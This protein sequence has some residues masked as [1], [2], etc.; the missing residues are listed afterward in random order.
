MAEKFLIERN[1]Y[2]LKG[3]TAKSASKPKVIQ[4]ALFDFF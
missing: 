1:N 4:L 2:S 3:L